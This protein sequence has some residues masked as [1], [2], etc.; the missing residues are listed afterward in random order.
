[1][2]TAGD[3]SGRVGL[4]PDGFVVTWDV[5]GLEIRAPDRKNPPLRLTWPQLQELAGRAGVSV[6]PAGSP[7]AGATDRNDLADRGTEEALRTLELTAAATEKEIREAIAT[8]PGSGT[9]TGSGAGGAC[10][11]RHAP[12]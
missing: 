7:H 5:H 9:P 8:W 12:S 1:M 3:K 11:P 6:R 2:A 10:A 4:I